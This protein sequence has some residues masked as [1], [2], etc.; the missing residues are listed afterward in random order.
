[1]LRKTISLSAT[2]ATSLYAGTLNM[3]SGWNLK[4]AIDDI[5][6]TSISTSECQSIWQYND[7]N[8]TWSLYQ[9]YST[10]SNYGYTPIPVPLYTNIH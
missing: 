1:M 2:L 10:I 5:N 4:G 8:G 6:T 9:T 7:N 3:D